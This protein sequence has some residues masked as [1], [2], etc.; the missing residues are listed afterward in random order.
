MTVESLEPAQQELL[1]TLVTAWQQKRAEFLL[2]QVGDNKSLL[3]HGGLPNRSIPLEEFEVMA[4]ARAG[5]VQITHNEGRG[6]LGFIL[7]P[8]ALQSVRQQEQH[9]SQA[10]SERHDDN[11]ELSAACAE[12]L[13]DL[14]AAWETIHPR[15][16]FGIDPSGHHVATINHPGLPDGKRDIPTLHLGQLETAGMIKRNEWV[17]H[18]APYKAYFT[19]TERGRR[20]VTQRNQTSDIEPLRL[21]IVHGHDDLLRLQVKEFLQDHLRLPTPIVLRDQPDMGR[22]LIEK[23]EE[24]ADRVDA[25]VVLLTPDDKTTDDTGAADSFRARQNVIL[26]LGYFLGKFGRKS[27]RVL[28]LFKKPLQIPSDIDGVTY[29]DVT[30]GVEAAS[31]KIQRELRELRP[32]DRGKS[33]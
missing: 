29:I 6:E 32:L 23:F 17:P 22:T 10:Q 27:G 5:L 16:E 28:L 33:S 13:A 31:V 8:A 19:L 14:V 20:A 3:F 9:V 18:W 30:Q 4:L 2:H 25:A 15:Q 26:E 12:L 11:Q 24:H 7:T 21:F 1:A